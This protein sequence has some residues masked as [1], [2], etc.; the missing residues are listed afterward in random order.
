[1]QAPES[2]DQL[3]AL[4]RM[5]WLGHARRWVA[6][7]E[8]VMGALSHDGFQE[9]QY[10]TARLARRPPAGGVWQG[11]NPR[12]GAVA[13]GIW[14]ARAQSERPLMFIDIDGTAITG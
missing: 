1:M 12:T 5:V 2:L 6:E 7:P 9:V 3:R 4:G 14:V 10:E 13:S 11:L 8:E